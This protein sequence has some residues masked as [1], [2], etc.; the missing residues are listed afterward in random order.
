HEDER[1]RH[2]ARRTTGANLRYEIAGHKFKAAT[3]AISAVATA[4]VMIVGGFAVRDNRLSIGSL[5]VLMSYFVA[6]YS[7]LETLAYLTEGF[8]TAKA[9]ARRVLAILEEDGTPIGDSPSSVPMPTDPL[10]CGAD[11]R[12]ENVSFG[13]T[14]EREALHDISFEV[15][16]GEM[17]A[18]VGETG[19]GKST[20]ISMW[21]R[22]FD[23]RSGAIHIDGRDIREITLES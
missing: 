17:V 12:F 11:V 13:Y 21:F 4:C 10:D 5:L 23:P 16:P 1:F 7:P 15:A 9:G 19:A 18:I 2:L 22:L 20:L 3:G 8:S 6:L 14:A